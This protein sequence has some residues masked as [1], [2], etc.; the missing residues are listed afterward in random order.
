M[1]PTLLIA[2]AYLLGAIPFGL[3]IGMTR[4]VDIRTLGSR[5]IGATNA[6]RVLGRKWG[7]VCLVL[8]ILK[9]FAPT[10]LASLWLTHAAGPQRQLLLLGVAA[11]AVLGHVFP[12]Y[13]RFRGGK[14]VATTVGVALGLWPVYTLAMFAALIGYGIARFL[15]ST[16]SVGS[17]TLAVV[18]P[19]ACVGYIVLTSETLAANWPL[20]LVS[21]LL[22]A[23]IIVRHL[24]NI[25]RLLHREEH[26]LQ[27]RSEETP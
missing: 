4:G 24:E 23:L 5:N 12:V 7:Y 26:T 2:G 6:G 11:A 25:R 3:L 9:G 20:V 22:G 17:L 10:L 19:A 13:L 8:D 21:V 18:F 15:T 16:V 14:G 27:R 1:L